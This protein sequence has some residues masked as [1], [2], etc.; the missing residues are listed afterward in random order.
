MFKKEQVIPFMYTCEDILNKFF[1]AKSKLKKHCKVTKGNFYY[2]NQRQSEWPRYNFILGRDEAEW[3]GSYGE[4]VDTAHLLSLQVMYKLIIKERI[5]KTSIYIY[6][7]IYNWETR[8]K[9]KYIAV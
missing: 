3:L 9:K 6:I 2:K 8:K 1:E 4:H 5:V 7:Y